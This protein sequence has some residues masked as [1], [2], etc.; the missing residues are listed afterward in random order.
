MAE[1]SETKEKDGKVVGTIP[2]P[3][4][5]DISSIISKAIVKVSFRCGKSCLYLQGIVRSPRFD[6]GH[7]PLPVAIWGYFRVLHSPAAFLCL[8]KGLRANRS[9]VPPYVP[10]NPACREKPWVL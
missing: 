3:S 2:V 1:E 7:G 5:N 4:D 8:T 10:R 6:L 9:N